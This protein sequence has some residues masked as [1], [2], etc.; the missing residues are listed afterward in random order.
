MAKTKATKGRTPQHIQQYKSE[1]LQNGGNISVTA[2]KFRMD[3][4]TLYSIINGS[5]ELQDTLVQARET[6]LDF[7]EGLLHSQIKENPTLLIFFLKTQGK[8]RGYVER[9]EQSVDMTAKHSI[10]DLE[11]EISKIVGK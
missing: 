4:N 6:M 11:K 9:V 8:K 2:K 1:L 10:D 7:A 3:R 5:K